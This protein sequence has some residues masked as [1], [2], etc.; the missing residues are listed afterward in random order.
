MPPAAG[1]VAPCGTHGVVPLIVGPVQPAEHGAV[2]DLTA[3][4]YLGGGFSST[5][6][7]PA[8][9]DV[10]RRAREATVLVARR[11]GQLLGAVTVATR[12]GPW[13]EQAVRGDAV[14]R[15]LAVSPDARRSG[16]GEA[17]MRSC[18]DEARTAGCTVVRLFSQADM[19]TAHRL[20]GRLGFVRAPSFDW[21]PPGLQLRAY[22]L[23]LVP[24]C[25]HCGAALTAEGHAD[26]RRM[27]E[28]DPPRYCP[29]CRRRT[30][31]QVTPAGWSARCSEHGLRSG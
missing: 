28:L 27:A 31:V 11:A 8:L 16:V 20:Y 14:V 19:T 13:A 7:E 30:V 15:M 3:A 2:A 22:A 10:A 4:V 23:P 21:A 9:R 6:Y 12:G 18:L 24:W 17:L 25:G 5:D 29:H 1:P 26:C